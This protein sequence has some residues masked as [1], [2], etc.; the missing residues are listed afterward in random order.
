VSVERDWSRAAIRERWKRGLV[1]LLAAA[2][3]GA[4]VTYLLSDLVTAPLVSV[5]V[6]FCTVAGAA[7]GLRISYWYGDLMNRPW[8]RR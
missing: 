5:A 1:Y 7:L 3:F 2:G 4:V 8:G 6:I